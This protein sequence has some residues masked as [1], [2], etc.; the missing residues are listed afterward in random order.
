MALPSQLSFVVYITI[1]L[2]ILFRSISVEVAFTS[3]SILISN[4]VREQDN[5]T[6]Q[7]ICQ[8]IGSMGWIAGPLIAGSLYSLSLTL[9]IRLADLG[10]WYA[11]IPLEKVPFL[12]VAI[13]A[14][15]AFVIALTVPKRANMRL[16]EQDTIEQTQH[17]K[18]GDEEM[19][20]LVVAE[21]PAVE[22]EEEKANDNNETN[23]DVMVH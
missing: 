3:H 8:L 9:N 20:D 22:E 12:T 4:S 16:D 6:I 13:A 2:A 18:L 10:G 7:G 17:Q 15:T 19:C 23:V 14:I 5:G 21:K 1:G 11:H